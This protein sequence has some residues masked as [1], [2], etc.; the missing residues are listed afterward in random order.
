M[1]GTLRMGSSDTKWLT[2]FSVAGRTYWPSGLLRSAQTCSACNQLC[3]TDVLRPSHACAALTVNATAASNGC[4]KEN[5]A[6]SVRP[7][8]G[9]AGWGTLA[10]M[11][12]GAM[13]TEQVT[14]VS[15]RTRPRSASPTSAPIVPGS[16]C[17]SLQM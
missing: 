1:P 8:Q 5:N 3:G 10:S 11:R 6:V 16:D 7:K 15:S 13:P 2:A 4:A 17:H 14:P 12:L 9:G